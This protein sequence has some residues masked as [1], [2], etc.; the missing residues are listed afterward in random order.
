MSFQIQQLYLNTSCLSRAN[1][2]SRN[3]LRRTI[4]QNRQDW[5]EICR[6]A[7]DAI[8]EAKNN[9]WKKLLQNSMSDVNCSDMWKVIQGLN[10][11]TDTNS[12]NE[13]T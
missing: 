1:I 5:I 2:R 7:N 6:E 13:A 11:T 9:S 3:C 10:G 8:N 4:H 12:P